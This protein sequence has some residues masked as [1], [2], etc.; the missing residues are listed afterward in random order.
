MGK[1][2]TSKKRSPPKM[3]TNQASLPS[4]RMNDKD[5][6]DFKK[7]SPVELAEFLK[8]ASLGDYAEAF[9]NHKISGR[10]ASQLTDQDLKDMGIH[11]VG[12]RLRLKIIIQ[13][14]G[15]QARYD[16]R[17]KVWWEGTENLYFSHGQKMCYTCAGCCPDGGPSRVQINVLV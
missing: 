15:M 14:L 12:D 5:T 2:S 13:S 3:T 8:K 7:W 4:Y 6:S 11:I 9:I 10:L 16:N 17:V 1:V